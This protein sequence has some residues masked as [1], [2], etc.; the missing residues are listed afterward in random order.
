[1][2]SETKKIGQE[3][4][5]IT[6]EEV[7]AWLQENPDFFIHHPEILSTLKLSPPERGEHVIDLQQFQMQKMRQELTATQDRQ[8]QFIKT[9]HANLNNQIRIHSSVLALLDARSAEDLILTI[10]SDLPKYLDLDF[11]S[12]VIESNEFS[13]T[14]QMNR[15]G[16]QIVETGMIQQI[17]GQS[18]V[19]LEANITGDPLIWGADATAVRSQA[20]ARLNIGLNTTNGI[21]AF[22][23]RNPNTFHVDQGPELVLFLSEVV[24]RCICSWLALLV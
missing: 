20:L 15:A 3:K 21:L 11:A 2:V 5:T 18:D 9:T 13:R 16:V 12:L 19:I 23:A 6:E 17:I 24:Q 22:G 4:K 14:L 10:T 1:M 8:R 7:A